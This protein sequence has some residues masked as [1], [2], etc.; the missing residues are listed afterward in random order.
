MTTSSLASRQDRDRLARTGRAPRDASRERLRIALLSY[1]GNPR[2]GGQG[3]YV[4]HLSRELVGLGHD[5][6]VL[7]G[8]PYPLIDDG[9]GFIPV[10]SLDLYR[11]PNPFRRPRLREIE[12]ATDL[13]ELTTMWT[14][15]FPEPRTFGRRARFILE[16]RLQSF[17]LLHDNQGLAPSL[18]DLMSHGWP[19]LT[20]IH[21]PITVDR[22]LELQAT[23]NPMRRVSLR[24]WY[25]FS[26]MQARVARRIPKIVTVSNS[27]RTDIAASLHISQ[28]RIAVIPVGVDEGVFYPRPAIARVQG[29]I[30]A[31]ASADI[32]L[33]GLV[34]LLE[35][36]AKLRSKRPDAHLVVIGKLRDKSPS[37]EAIGRLG[38][39]RVVSFVTG[40]TDEHV[41]RRYAQASCAV[42]P[43]LYEG[44]SLPAIEAMAC[45]VPLVATT[46]GALPEV[47]GDD[48]KSA[49]L[50]APGDPGA[51]ANAMGRLLDDAP[52]RAKLG[53]AGRRRVL[54]RFTWQQC[55]RST[56]DQYRELLE[57]VRPC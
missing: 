33:K 19:V 55:A 18:L 10:P 48:E 45:A 52:L 51:L 1:R 42:V 9:V 50:V 6:T 57:G 46:G 32:A 14:G 30:M 17:D 44:F 3:V 20:S 2:S 39:E 43:S 8:Q 40:E 34:P 31:T 21:H 16:G 38:L 13:F 56:V 15:G 28:E 23:R 36:L 27:S 24:R 37:T 11:E 12:S 7:A 29:R 35:A 47:V 26:R 4:R 53:D 5:V 25:G 41:A 22:A 54:A 49:L